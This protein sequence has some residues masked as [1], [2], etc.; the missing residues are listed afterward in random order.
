MQDVI[1]EMEDLLQELRD[2][3]GDPVLADR[4]E[5]ARILLFDRSFS[6]EPTRESNA[7]ST[8]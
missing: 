1:N 4:R 6:T 3:V 2:L 5:D 8:K 7:E